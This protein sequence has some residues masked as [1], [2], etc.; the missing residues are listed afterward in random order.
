M[1]LKKTRVTV[2]EAADSL[3]VTSATIRT[4][5]AEDRFTAIRPSGF[6]R[7]KRFYLFEDELAEYNET[8]KWDA[9][10]RLRIKKGRL[11]KQKK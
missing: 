8:G 11:E 6:G 1:V 3:G 7:G 5:V 2:R 10:K 4:Y 9:V